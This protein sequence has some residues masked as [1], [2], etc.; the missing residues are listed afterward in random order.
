[1]LDAQAATDKETST[2]SK[3]VFTLKDCHVISNSVLLL[4]SGI[5]TTA[6]TLSFALYFLAAQPQQQAAVHNEL[7]GVIT[8]GK[9][10]SFDELE[11]LKHLDMVVREALRLFP[12]VPLMV[13]RVCD[14]DTNVMGQFIPAGVNIL[15]PAWHIQ[16]DPQLWP[17][18]SKFLPE[19]FLEDPTERNPVTFLPFGLGP[20]TCLAKRLALFELKTAIFKI[21]AAYEITLSDTTKLPVRAVVPDVILRPENPIMLNL[22]ARETIKL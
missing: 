11:N 7:Q 17:E 13:V 18:P 3:N 16:R 15:V 4:L 22:R 6:S 2:V 19:R 20:R 1:M 9:D 10:V 12:A 8:N 21:L 5:E 14:R